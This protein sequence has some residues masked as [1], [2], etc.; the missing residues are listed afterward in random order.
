[1]LI[2]SLRLVCLVLVLALTLGAEA[3]LSVRVNRTIARGAAHIVSTQAAD[4]SWQSEDKVHP[5]GRTALCTYTLLHAGYGEDHAAVKKGLAFLGLAG[6][7]GKPK[8]P[9][10][11]Y[12]AGCLMFLMHALGSSHDAHMRRVGAW[13][14]EHFDKTRGLWG[15]P[16]GDPDLSN[17]QY[18]AFGLALAQRHGYEVP[19]EVWETLVDSVPRLQSKRGDFRY[20]ADQVARATMTHAALLVLH[21]A[22]EG[23]SHRKLPRKLR[24]SVKAGHRWC[25]EHFAVDRNPFGHGWHPGHY[26]YYMYGLERYAVLFEKKTIGGRDWYSEGAE[27]LIAQQAAEGSWRGDVSNTCFAILFLRRAVFSAPRRRDQPGPDE[28]VDG[29]PRPAKPRPA[30]DVEII[31]KWL[32]AGPY[33]SR[34]NED[35]MLLTQPFKVKKARPAGGKPAGS[36]RWQIAE[37]REDGRLDFHES[38]ATG[39]HQSYVAALWLTVEEQVDCVLWFDSDD[40]ALLWLDGE[41]ILVGHHHD[42]CGDDHYRIPMSLAPGSHVL[43]AQVEN[44]GYYCHMRAKLSDADGQP[45]DRV[46]ITT[47]KPRR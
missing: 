10:S 33:R 5:L 26:Y 17:T 43:L 9:R 32:V 40:G 30:A 1:M 11:T 12:E 14:V 34:P 13:L 24:A 19:R 23:L 16:D 41:P 6:D 44:L 21:L 42:H 7:Y 45:T 35:E 18:A 4:G 31:R 15:Y 29:E 27:E 25:D 47:A 36:A 8:M 39:D 2:R 22:Q 37:S 38:V 3:P 46:R 28:V 20:K